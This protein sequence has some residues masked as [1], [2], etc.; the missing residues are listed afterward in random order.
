MI[1]RK[2]QSLEK[3]GQGSFGSIHRGRNIKTD[4][5]VAIKFETGNSDDKL[6]LLKHETT[7][8]NY[9]YNSG[10]RTVPTVYWFGNYI[11]SIA[12]V[13]PLY[14]CSMTTMFDKRVNNRNNYTSVPKMDDIMNSLISGLNS[15]HKHGIIHRDIKP[16]NI[17]YNGSK[18]VFID[19]GFATS[20]KTDNGKHIEY[21]DGHTTLIGSP[22]YA[23]IHIHLGVEPTR[24]DDFIS[25]G[26]VYLYMLFGEL[27]W[28]NPV[29][30][31][32]VGQF[33]NSLMNTR[34][35]QIATAKSLENIESLRLSEN[36]Y[37]YMDICYQLEF[38]ESIGDYIFYTNQNEK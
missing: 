38:E 11:D 3:I 16:D 35:L 19:F 15:I 30:N 23:S 20:Y 28:I 37:R 22:K 31:N 18:F 26:Y 1:G 29:S 32:T 27:N 12:L 9:L 13:I 10:C 4:E 6:S 5:S 8:L 21:K 25:L 2:Y 14:K 17:M 33:E 36:I 7:I 24:R 34:L